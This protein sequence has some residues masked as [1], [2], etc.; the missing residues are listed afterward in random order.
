MAD[1]FTIIASRRPPAH[2]YPPVGHQLSPLPSS[3][4]SALCPFQVQTAVRLLQTLT[5]R[6]ADRDARATCDRETQTE[7]PTRML[8]EFVSRNKERVLAL[9]GVGADGA[10]VTNAAGGLRS[11]QRGVTFALEMPAAKGENA[12][13]S[14][15][16]S[17]V[18]DF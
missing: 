2:A 12:V 9:L 13:R 15:A 3:D 7:F 4:G 5:A 17:Q 6:P 16:P 11:P 8:E 10:R 1:A 18:T 14:R